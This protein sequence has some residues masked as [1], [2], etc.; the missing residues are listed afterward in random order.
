MPWI[1]TLG[2]V[3]LV[4]IGACND[5]DL[6][7]TRRDIGYISVNAP[8]NGQRAATAEGIF[9]HDPGGVPLPNSKAVLDSC[10]VVPFSPTGALL[11]PGAVTYLDAG[12]SIAMQTDGGIGFL[13][14]ITLADGTPAYSLENADALPFTPGAAVTFTIPGAPDAFAGASATGKMAEPYTLGPIDTAV[15]A[16]EGLPITWSPAGDD[17]SRFNLSLQYASAGSST[18]DK[19]IFCS[20]RDDGVDT[21]PARLLHEWRTATG[22]RPVESFRWRSTIQ[23]TREVVL[24]VVTK[25][26]VSKST[27]P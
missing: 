14:P 12:D 5:N 8:V 16:T 2:V 13:T 22:P 19:Q 18:P 24:D 6:P 23:G 21:V 4:V 20:L 9:F 7:S 3:G 25:Y 11:T 17:S 10:Q 27:L 1:R 26:N 15:A